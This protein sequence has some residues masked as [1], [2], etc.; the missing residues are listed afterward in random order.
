MT[1]PVRL[2]HIA[3]IAVMLA[4]ID[5]S[6]KAWAVSELR[7]GQIVLN[8][9]RPWHLVPAAVLL[10]AGL[11]AVARTQLLAIGAG[12]VIGGGLGNLGE[13]ALFG[14]VTDFVPLG[15]PFK[16]AVWSP[17]DAF[18]AAGLVVLWVGAVRYEVTARPGRGS[19]RRSRP[20]AG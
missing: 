5:W 14:R 4:V 2:L 19:R 8:T 10:G 11:V 16:G 17:A 9:D 1:L 18:L 13:Y 6:L 12:I 3:S 7:P 15:F 20:A